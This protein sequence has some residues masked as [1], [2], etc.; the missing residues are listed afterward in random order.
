MKPVAA[1]A[2]RGT[3]VGRTKFFRLRRDDPQYNNERTVPAW[4][5]HVQSWVMRSQQAA[6]A[7]PPTTH[8]YGAAPRQTLDLYTPEAE[9]RAL[10]VFFHGGYWHRGDKSLV[11]FLVPALLEQGVTVA[12]A[13][14]RLFPIDSLQAMTDD[15][16][17]V[18]NWLDRNVCRGEAN[19]AGIW[20]SG[21]SAG[22][23]LAACACSRQARTR[24]G[25]PPRVRGTLLFS[26]IYDLSRL[27]GLPFLQKSTRISARDALRLSPVRRQPTPGT[28]HLV[29]VGAGES[30]AFRHQSADLVRR[31]PGAQLTQVPDA[32]HFTV[33]D[34]LASDTNLLATIIGHA[35]ERARAGASR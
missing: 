33:L 28:R 2:K 27:R 12:L 31:W 1:H 24:V 10:L 8:A 18:V 32:N 13:N 20:L 4:Q 29:L 34:A 21:H 30:A 35:G 3:A 17:Q 19:T 22:A 14:Y 16:R 5:T 6:S 23:H 25:L 26:G 11:A 7:T 9:S 15:A